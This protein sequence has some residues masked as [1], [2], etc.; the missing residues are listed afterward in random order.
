[1]TSP[2]LSNCSPLRGAVF[3][4]LLLLVFFLYQPGLTGI[5]L[6]D[7]TTNLQELEQIKQEASLDNILYFIGSGQ[8]SQLARPIAMLSFATQAYAWPS[9]PGIFKFVNVA[10][11]LLNGCFI[12]W[13][14]IRLTR[15]MKLDSCQAQWLALLATGIWLIHPLNVSTTLY[16]IQ[17]MT[18]LATLFTLMGI[19]AYLHGRNYLLKEEPTKLLTG[20]LWMSAGVALGAI[21]ATL[22]KENGVLLPLF[23][24]ITEATLLRHAPRPGPWRSWSG[25]FLITPLILLLL[26]FGMH[27]QQYFVLNYQMREFTLLERVLTEFRVLTDYLRMIFLPSLAGIGLFHDDYPISTG[28]LTPPTTLAAMVF[29]IALL[30]AGWFWRAKAPLFAFGVLWF[31]GGHMLESTFLS[32][33][34][35]FEHR[36]YFP[37]IGLWFTVVYGGWQLWQQQEKPI[38]RKLL[39]TGAVVLCLLYGFLTYSESRLWGAPIQQAEVWATNQPT[40]KRAQSQ[41][42]EFL[43]I[44]NQRQQAAMIYEKLTQTIQN[45][46]GAYL[47]WLKLR[48][49]HPEVPL[50]DQT[51]LLE[52]MRTGVIHIPALELVV[53][54]MEKGVCPEIEPQLMLAILQNVQQSPTF[55]PK[56][57]QS[58]IDYYTAIIEKMGGELASAM[59]HLESALRHNPSVFLVIIKVAWLSQAQQFEEARETLQQ[60]HLYNRGNPLTQLLDRQRIAGWQQMLEFVIKNTSPPPISQETKA[61]SP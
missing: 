34:L 19:L 38:I 12:F 20:Y 50:P 2:A 4:I 33:E 29:I 15:F 9:A 16:V 49:R 61:L 32:L 13:I 8:A 44:G 37:A 17:R 10:L 21:L 55:V 14:F 41:M 60:A 22:S 27:W 35:Y 18:Q 7:D 39:A 11:H 54:T 51:K 59:N 23:I 52:R 47:Y 1:M 46:T 56:S 40:S 30:L 48:C 58:Q 5:F 6:L 3:Y 42:A 45:D 36:N 28:L 31:F 24:L 43:A 25:L 26:Y 57:H 53:Y